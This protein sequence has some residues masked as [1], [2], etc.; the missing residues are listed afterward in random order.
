MLL[1][2]GQTCLDVCSEIARSS[3]HEGVQSVVTGK[4]DEIRNPG[5]RKSILQGFRISP[6]LADNDEVP[7]PKR[8]RTS[9]NGAS[10]SSNGTSSFSAIQQIIDLRRENKLEGLKQ[11]T[12]Y[13][14][15]ALSY[16]SP[17]SC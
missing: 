17:T 3:D 14:L 5:L 7:N 12:K 13:V 2:K 9:I 10:S 1:I 11:S 15:C 6:S 16:Q 8:Q 4:L